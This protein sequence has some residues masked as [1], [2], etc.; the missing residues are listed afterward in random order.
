MPTAQAGAGTAPIRFL[1]MCAMRPPHRAA[2]SAATLIRIRVRPRLGHRLECW[3][4]PNLGF[5]LGYGY[6]CM[7]IYVWL[8]LEQHLPQLGSTHLAVQGGGRCLQRLVCQARS[9]HN[10]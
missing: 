1:S 4:S 9:Q 5:G 2:T 10:D 7:A 8:R 3:L 6:M